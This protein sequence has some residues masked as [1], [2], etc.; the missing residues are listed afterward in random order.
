MTQNSIYA[1][2]GVNNWHLCCKWS[3]KRPFM[4]FSERFSAF[5]AILGAFLRYFWLKSANFDKSKKALF[6][7]KSIANILFLC[8]VKFR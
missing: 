2:N 1:V 3:K 7:K 8:Y 6:V 5:Y 4:L